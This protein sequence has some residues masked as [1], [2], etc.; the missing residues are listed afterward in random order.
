MSD[1]VDIRP[2]LGDILNGYERYSYRPE[3]SIAEFV[4]NSTASYYQNQAIL[5]MLG[6]SLYISINYDS[7]RGILTI[8]D[9]AW[10]MDKQ[11]F[12]NALTIAKRPTN[13]TGRNEYGMGLKT[14]ASWFGKKWT[15]TTK[16]RGCEEEYRATIDIEELVR[17]KK[18]EIEITSRKANKELHYT[19]IRISNLNKKIQNRT[20]EKLKDELSS[21]YRH[22]INT[23]DISITVNEEVLS[24]ELPEIYKENVDG[25]ERTWKKDFSDKVTF[26]GKDY[27]FNGFVALRNVGNYKETGFA[28]LRR[29]RVIVGGTEKNFKPSEIFGSA[30]S[31]QSLRIFGEVNLDNWPVTQAKD[32]F[33]WD[34][35]G[36]KEVFID[37]LRELVEDYI[38][39]AKNTRK[40]EKEVK[41]IVTLDDVKE[42]ADETYDDLKTLKEIRVAPKNDI[43]TSAFTNQN[44]ILIPSYTTTVNILRNTYHIK[45]EFISDMDEELVT[46]KEE[47]NTKQLLVT[48]NTAHPYFIDIKDKEGFTKVFQ[49]YL[50]LQ[51]IA[52]KYLERISVNDGMVYPY[53]IRETINRMLEE[54]KNNNGEEIFT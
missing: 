40:K 2:S 3:T 17:N 23:G 5:K 34:L 43:T 14:A 32:A 21:I 47:K 31:F 30:N 39:K 46:V 41:S 1:S 26:N 19:I 15:V 10:G 18:N 28:L 11:T 20:I 49:K 50:I 53:E 13:Q 4:D 27:P 25:I 29:G 38:D 7:S 54:I 9:N 16:T 33:D 37:K 22:D 44:N 6:Q 48:F 8:E 51:I 42:I 52:E 12:S 35:D 36:L 24:Y 45:V